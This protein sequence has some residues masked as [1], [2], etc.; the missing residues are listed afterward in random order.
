MKRSIRIKISEPE[1]VGA[2]V[3]YR[4]LTANGTLSIRDFDTIDG[5]YD[6]VLWLAQCGTKLERLRVEEIHGIKYVRKI[7]ISEIL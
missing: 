5:V 4:L 7:E 1:E 6:H 2:V 3:R